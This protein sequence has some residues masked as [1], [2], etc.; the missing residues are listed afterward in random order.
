MGGGEGEGGVTDDSLLSDFYIW[1]DGRTISAEGPDAELGAR[2]RNSVHVTFVDFTRHPNGMI[3]KY[4][5][6]VWRAEERF[7]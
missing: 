1:V 4:L 5:S 2:K 7:A 3:S 6:Q